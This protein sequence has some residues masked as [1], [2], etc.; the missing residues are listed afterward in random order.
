[1]T[2]VNIINTFQGQI[3]SKVGKWLGSKNAD[4]KAAG[5]CIHTYT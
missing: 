5:C 4:S 3:K 2:K 1:M